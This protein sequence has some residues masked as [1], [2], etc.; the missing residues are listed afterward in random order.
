MAHPVL[1]ISPDTAGLIYINGR[2]AGECDA[3][4]PLSIPVAPQGAVYIEYHPL[5][6]GVLGAARRLNLSGGY[7]SPLSEPPDGMYIVAWPGS[8]IDVQISPERVPVCGGAVRLSAGGYDVYVQAGDACVARGAVLMN[9]RLPAG[10]R[11]VRALEAGTE[12]IMLIGQCGEGEFIQIL[13]PDAGKVLLSAAGR[14]ISP[15]EYGAVRV[16]REAGDEA[17]HELIEIWQSGA[18]GY[19][20]R[21]AA[22]HGGSALPRTPESAALMLG[23]AILLGQD[24]EAR[25]L[26]SPGAQAGYPTIRAQVMRFNACCALKYGARTGAVGLMRVA[27]PGYARVWEMEFDAA[28]GGERWLIEGIRTGG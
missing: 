14:S 16:E 27:G 8:V 7:V 15:A 18:H 12:R 9:V 17:G 3:Q 11:S 23:Q 2:L 24:E 28:R 20:R 25:A 10:A 26:L 22:V 6:A 5:C 13:A 4:S 21:T 1:Y 19:T